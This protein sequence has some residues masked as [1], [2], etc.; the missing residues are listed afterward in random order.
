M[1]AGDR[2]GP[3]LEAILGRLLTVGTYGAIGLVGVGVVLMLVT[4]RAPLAGDAAPFDPRAIPGLIAAGR[5]EGLLWLG[6]LAAIAT[7]IGRVTG[8]LIG[9][10]TR[11]ER[12]LAVVAAAIL[13]VIAT[14]L[15]LAL[16]A[17]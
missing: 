5:P 3:D 8:A 7:P 17:A 2:P 6:L 4:G 13:A 16:V 15:V 12:L 9:F 14:A 1:T 10:T 11:G